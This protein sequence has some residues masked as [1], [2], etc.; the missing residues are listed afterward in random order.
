MKVTNLA[1]DLI[2]VFSQFSYNWTYDDLTSMFDSSHLGVEYWEN[3][4]NEVNSCMVNLYMVAD[5]VHRKM[6][7]NYIVNEK[8]PEMFRSRNKIIPDLK[9]I[10]KP[11]SKVPL[12]LVI[13]NTSLSPLKRGNHSE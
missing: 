8:Y 9:K 11:H 12:K 10:K 2:Y 13:D 7:I 5:S 6:M 4:L 1:L 3:R